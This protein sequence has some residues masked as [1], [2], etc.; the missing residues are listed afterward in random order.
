MPITF[1]SNFNKLNEIQKKN[2]TTHC[3]ELKLAHDSIGIN[4]KTIFFFV[5]LKLSQFYWMSIGFYL[6]IKAIE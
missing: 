1:D 4:Q 2:S 6:S 5:F 3:N